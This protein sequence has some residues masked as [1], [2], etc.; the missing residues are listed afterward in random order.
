MTAPNSTAGRRSASPLATA[1]YDQV[2]NRI[3]TCVLQPGDTIAGH[4]LAKEM[5]VSR[6]PVH[7]A[8][9][10][11]TAEGYLRVSPRVGYSVTSL[12]VRDLRNLFEIRMTLDG[13][14][15]ELA[16]RSYH[17]RWDDAFRA[18]EEEIHQLALELEGRHLSDPRLL[19]AQV[20]AHRRFHE[21]LFQ[22]AGNDRLQ[23]IAVPLHDETQRYWFLVPENRTRHV[24]NVWSSPG[25]RLILDA[26]VA[27][28]AERARATMQSHLQDGL[29]LILEQ[30]VPDLPA[31][32]RIDTPRASSVR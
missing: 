1:V 28:D 16:A 31:S 25:H 20:A 17:Q 4:Q 19:Q 12:S 22:I 29:R 7:D 14:G 5:N 9:K 11:L 26:V 23:R 18:A 3:L 10:R 8:L 6:T 13:L 2:K 32:H 24:E 27:G 30:L 21:L 15:A